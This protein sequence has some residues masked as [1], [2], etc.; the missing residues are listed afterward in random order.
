MADRLR[1]DGRYRIRVKA[2]NPK[3]GRME[4]IKRV[5]EAKSAA[6]AA[7]MREDARNTLERDWRA[8]RNGYVSPMPRR[9]GF[10]GSCPG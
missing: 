5:V 4:I 6:E 8:R 2:R 3:T 10:V 9:R 1:E 7:A